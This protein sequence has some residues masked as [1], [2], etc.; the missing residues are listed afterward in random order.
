MTALRLY[1]E[2]ERVGPLFRRAGENVATAVRAAAVDAAVSIQE[3]GRADIK[4][5]PGNWGSRWTEGLQTQVSEGGGSIRIATT[6]NIPY[7][8][9]F[10]RGATIHGKPLLWIPF[11]FAADAKGIYARNFP[12][13]L[14]RVDRKSGGAPLLLSATDKQPKYF[15]K[16]SV[17][18]PKK[19]HIVEIIRDVAKMIADFYKNHRQG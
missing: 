18:I 8:Q 6:H 7:F 5:A 1:F 13:P 10:E 11:S 3:R 12:E 17:T 2:G 15:G 19:F 14:F 4:A 16:E 9:V